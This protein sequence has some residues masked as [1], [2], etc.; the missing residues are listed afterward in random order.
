MSLNSAL[1]QKVGIPSDIVSNIY[2]YSDT[3]K[4]DFDA[5][6]YDARIELWRKYCM[7][8]INSLEDPVLREAGHFWA[9]I[10]GAKKGRYPKK[11]MFLDKIESV[12]N[13]RGVKCVRICC[14]NNDCKEY[15]TY[16]INYK[17]VSVTNFN[18]FTRRYY[19]GCV[20]DDYLEFWNCK[21]A[22]YGGNVYK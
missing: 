18:G 12:I 7:R 19:R 14:F 13:D 2:S 20:D 1:I 11:E 8:Y 3:Y 16:Y 5:V 4:S 15:D 21:V 10:Y 9:H 17:L 6:I 22:K